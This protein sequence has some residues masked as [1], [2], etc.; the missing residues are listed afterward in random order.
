M[1]L[2]LTLLCEG[3]WP[4]SRSVRFTPTKGTPVPISGGEPKVSLDAVEKKS[5]VPASNRNR[6]PRSSIL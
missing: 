3:E 1:Y 6:I 5:L 4:D 2:Y